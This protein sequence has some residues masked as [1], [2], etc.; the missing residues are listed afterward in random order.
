MSNK[1]KITEMNLRELNAEAAK[2]WNGQ[3]NERKFVDLF[4]DAQSGKEIP[5]DQEEQFDKWNEELRSI[6]VEIKI[7]EREERMAELDVRTAP[8]AT[9]RPGIDE[10]EEKFD[11]AFKPTE[12]E[13]RSATIK[14]AKRGQASL[15]TQEKKIFNLLER[16]ERAFVAAMKA[17]FDPARMDDETRT[18]L[19]AR[20]QRAQTVTTTGGGYLI[21]EGFMANVIKSLSMISPFFEEGVSGP[22]GVAQSTFNFLRTNS[23]NSIPWPTMDD[24][25][26]TGELLAINTSIGSATDLTFSR[27]V[28]LAYKYSSKPILVPYELFEDEG[29]GLNQLVTESLA[30]RI[31][32]IAN[33]HLTTGDNSSKPQGIVIGATSGKVSASATAVT[34]PEI[35]DLVHSVNPAYRKS[36]SCRFMMHDNILL[37]LKKLTVGS[38]TAN[39][40]PLWAPGYD[41]QAPATIDGFQYIVNQDMASSVAT[42]QK[43]ILFGDMKQYAVRLV[44]DVRAYKLEER[45]RD[46]DQTGFISFMRMDGRILNSAAIKYLRTT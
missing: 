37:Y 12:K 39:A 42:N 22:T 14:L 38:S 7:R 36:P 20:E 46:L 16:E 10:V 31:G 28:L 43:I 19:E 26:N 4:R 40:R 17:G 25:S 45:Y 32:R 30:T 29:V 8:K 3:M 44:N 2:I 33:T 11:P 24:T 5:K 9:G 27:V 41:V 35:I 23:G 6:D 18:I 15:N 34:F 1:K 21:P 13:V